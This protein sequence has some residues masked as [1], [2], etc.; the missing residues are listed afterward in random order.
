ML[1]PTRGTLGIPPRVTDH[2]GWYYSKI[3]RVIEALIVIRAIA[4]KS[5]VS[6]SP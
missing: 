3:L 2:A 4:A 6:T 1:N 5:V